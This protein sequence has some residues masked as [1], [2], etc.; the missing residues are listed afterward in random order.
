MN[1]EIEEYEIYLI[2]QSFA[3]MTETQLLGEQLYYRK[4]TV[5]EPS[6]TYTAAMQSADPIDIVANRLHV[7]VFQVSTSVGV[8]FPGWASFEIT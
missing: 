5:T 1:E 2:N 6:F 3:G 4:A 7:V 8:G